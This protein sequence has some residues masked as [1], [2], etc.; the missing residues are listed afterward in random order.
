MKKILVTCAVV[1]GLT[2]NY[3]VGFAGMPA[4]FADSP[5]RFDGQITSFMAAA[6]EVSATGERKTIVLTLSE[7]DIRRQLVEMVESKKDN[8]PVRVKDIQVHFGEG[9]GHIQVTA[10]VNYFFFSTRVSAD[11]LVTP[12]GRHGYYEVVDISTGSLPHFLVD[13][14]MREVP[15]DRSGPLPLGNLPVEIQNIFFRDGQL[16]IEA[17]TIPAQ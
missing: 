16:Y 3:L 12:E 13:W 6:R 7:E 4:V 17:I 15:Y 10:K 11:V 9:S 5:Q 2:S 1:L 14:I 8:I